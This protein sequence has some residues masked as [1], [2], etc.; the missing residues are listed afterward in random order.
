MANA[1]Q[2]DMMGRNWYYD[3]F[4]RFGASLLNNVRVIT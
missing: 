2:C 3:W 1:H 4:I